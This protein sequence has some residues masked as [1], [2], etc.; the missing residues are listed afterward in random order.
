MKDLGMMTVTEY[1]KGFNYALEELVETD[2]GIYKVTPEGLDL[3]W[4]S[5]GVLGNQVCINGRT[6][7]EPLRKEHAHA[8]KPP[9]GV[10]RQKVHDEIREGELGA[11][12]IRYVEA[13]KEVPIEWVDEYNEIIERWAE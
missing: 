7:Y 9:L 4:S 2:E 1:N 10:M 5:G 12:I 8:E 3:Q 11:A 6:Y 13:E